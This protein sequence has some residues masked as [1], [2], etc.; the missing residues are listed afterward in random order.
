MKLG[1]K[2]SSS[3]Q[4]NEKKKDKFEINEPPIRH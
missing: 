2:G 3:Q 1:K 4:E